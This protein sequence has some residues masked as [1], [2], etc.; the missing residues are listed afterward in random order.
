MKFRRAVY[1]TASLTLALLLLN[2][3]NPAAH[4]QLLPLPP[5]VPTFV[6]QNDFAA[7]NEDNSMTINVL[8]NDLGA[9]T[10]L[11]SVRSVTQPSNGVAVIVSSSIVRYTPDQDF[12]GDDSFTY[13]A[14]DATGLT[15]STA[16]VFVTVNPV[17]DP[18]VAV[19]DFVTTDE[20]T[21]VSFF[22]DANDYDLDV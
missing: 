2:S 12:N 15:R 14:S 8:A 21:P 9:G 16:T 5:L 19:D 22:A 11:F 1:G 7:T 13:T 4:A 18:P 10:G 6:A 17:N 20:D 3:V